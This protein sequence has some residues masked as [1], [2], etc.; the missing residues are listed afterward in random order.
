MLPFMPGNG[1]VVEAAWII[2]AVQVDH[3]AS[4]RACLLNRGAMG[5]EAQ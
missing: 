3:S 2:H 1:Q 5:F 4:T